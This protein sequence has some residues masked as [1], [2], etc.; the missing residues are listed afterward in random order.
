MG[1]RGLLQGEP[2]PLPS[3]TLPVT[4]FTI[5]AMVLSFTFVRPINS[6]HFMETEKVYRIQDKH[7]PPSSA[8]TIHST[9]DLCPMPAEPSPPM[10]PIVC[11]FNTVNDLQRTHYSNTRLSISRLHTVS[12]N[13]G[14]TSK[15]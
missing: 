10:I 5:K 6:L 8:S 14:A 12:K 7:M 15:F 3:H 4:N 9:N 13:L 2:L 1:L 11:Q